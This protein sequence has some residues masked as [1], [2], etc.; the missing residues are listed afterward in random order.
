MMFQAQNRETVYSTLKDH[1][2]DECDK[3]V[4]HNTTRLSLC[5]APA[6]SLG[7]LSDDA[8]LTSVCLSVAY[9]GPNSRTERPRKTKVGTESRLPRC[10][11]QPWASCLH[12]HV[13]RTPLS[14][15]K[16]QRST[17]RGGGILWRPP[18]QLVMTMFSVLEAYFRLL[19][20]YNNI[21]VTTTMMI[22]V[23]F[24]FRLR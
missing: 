24:G 11:V 4:F 19:R 3:I 2:D 14:R 9:I 22:R 8:R 1:Y 21:G 18:T 13:T 23:G 5:Y 15:S 10:R 6:P 17:G 7:A 16:G 12:T 20:H